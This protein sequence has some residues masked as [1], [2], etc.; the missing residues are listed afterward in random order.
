MNSL[1][2]MAARLLLVPIIAFA[3]GACEDDSATR[4]NIPGGNAESGK[5]LIGFYECGSCHVIPGVQGAEGVVGPPLN[6]WSRRSLIAGNVP[7]DPDNLIRWIVDPQAIE[8][9]T[10]MPNLGVTSAEA[11]DIAAFLYTLE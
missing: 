6:F 7:N 11:R 3:L 1:T 2:G 4:W 10:A 5:R 8:P 9:G